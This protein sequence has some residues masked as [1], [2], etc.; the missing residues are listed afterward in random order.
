MNKK[1]N[2]FASRKLWIGLMIVALL[3]PILPIA[4]T[5]VSHAE[6]DGDFTYAVTS[7]TEARVLYSSGSEVDL[8]IPASSVITG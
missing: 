4:P 7:D 1:M 3:G 5:P 8:V 2:R 6:V